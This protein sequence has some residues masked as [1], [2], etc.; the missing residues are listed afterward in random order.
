[1]R[2][3][4]ARYRF[5][6]ILIHW[7]LALMSFVLLGLGWYIQNRALTTW[8]YEDC[9]L[10]IFRRRHTEIVALKANAFNDSSIACVNNAYFGQ[11]GSPFE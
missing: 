3:R 6:L 9:Q 1:M 4:I 2:P 11:Y 5:S 10:E 7:V 8:Q